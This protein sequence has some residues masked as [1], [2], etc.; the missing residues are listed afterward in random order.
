MTKI[1]R[2]TIKNR[3]ICDDLAIFCSWLTALIDG[4]NFHLRIP[5]SYETQNE[6]DFP[7]I[8]EREK[9]K[10]SNKDGAKVVSRP[11]LFFASILPWGKC[12]KKHGKC[13]YSFFRCK[14]QRKCSIFYRPLFPFFISHAREGEKKEKKGRR[15][16][17]KQTIKGPFLGLCTLLRHSCTKGPSTHD[18]EFS[19]EEFLILV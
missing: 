15:R 2:K 8:M 12:P 13:V 7:F 4:K 18:E 19:D 17:S 5:F 6:I 1:Q 10:N 3:L 14:S 16:M 11:L 9:P